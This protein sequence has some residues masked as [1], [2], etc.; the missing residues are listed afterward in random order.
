MRIRAANEMIG[1]GI[2]AA[3]HGA[4]AD[5]LSYPAKSTHPY[6]VPTIDPNVLAAPTFRP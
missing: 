3:L 6:L 4:K 2:A 1:A 5:V